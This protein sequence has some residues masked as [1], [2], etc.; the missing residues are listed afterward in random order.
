MYKRIKA[1]GK[2]IQAVDVEIDKVIPMLDEVG[3]EGTFITLRDG[4]TRAEADRL[5]RDLEPYYPL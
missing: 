2:S 3:P 4:Y 5:Y 1:A